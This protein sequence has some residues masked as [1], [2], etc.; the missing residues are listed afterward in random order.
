MPILTIRNV[1][2]EVYDRLRARASA[3]RRSINSEAI[4]VL[5]LGVIGRPDRDVAGFLKRARA[6]REAG[7]GYVTD[8]QI[9]AARRKGRA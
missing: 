6:V 2:D 1:P 4:E 9:D 8:K 7:V 3:N 5:R